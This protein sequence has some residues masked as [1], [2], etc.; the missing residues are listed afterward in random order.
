[1]KIEELKKLSDTEL[2]E[3]LVE[4]KSELQDKRLAVQNNT[5]KNTS[6]LTKLRKDTARIYTIMNERKNNE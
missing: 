3:K 2:S 4:L 1:M 6:L 5:E